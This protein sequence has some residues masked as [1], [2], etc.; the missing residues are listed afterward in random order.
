[1]FSGVESDLKFK[2][3]EET[4]NPK[5]QNE[6]KQSYDQDAEILMRGNEGLSE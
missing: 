5:T 6:E 2:F 4:T 3:Y 1:M